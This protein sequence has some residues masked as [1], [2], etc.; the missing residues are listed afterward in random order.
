M[1]HAHS[2][3]FDENTLPK[4]KHNKKWVDVKKLPHHLEDT[5]AAREYC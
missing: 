2:L 5:M 4:K 3:A 1:P